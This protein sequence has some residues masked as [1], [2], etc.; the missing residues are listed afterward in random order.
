MAAPGE[1]LLGPTRLAAELG[2]HVQ[3]VHK[4]RRRGCPVAA[5]GPRGALYDLEA[6]K[7]WRDAH[8][9][10]MLQRP[11]K[12]RQRAGAKGEQPPPDQNDSKKEE[13]ARWTPEGTGVGPVPRG[14]YEDAPARAPGA[15]R[16][17]TA[18]DADIDYKWTKTQ[19]ARMELLQRSGELLAADDV[20]RAWASRVAAARAVVEGLPR[21]IATQVCGALS[22][23]VREAPK[24]QRVLEEAFEEVIEA[25]RTAGKS[26]TSEAR[27]KKPRTSGR[28]GRKKRGAS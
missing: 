5:E 3:M 23:H 10:P 26:A 13:P 24:V 1:G 19:L 28:G 6:V 12:T 25:L 11:R 17:A 16:P 14:T 7:R 4:M 2:L 27:A 18:A 8:I 15:G 21:S 9:S 22:I 20:R